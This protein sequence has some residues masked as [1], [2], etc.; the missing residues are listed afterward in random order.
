[1]IIFEKGGP[2]NTQACCSIAVEKAIELGCD[3]VSATS[4]G[5]SAL[6]MS[7][8][9]AEMGFKGRLVF[10]THAYGSREPGKNRMSDERRKELLDAGH[11]LVTA[12]HLLSGAERGLSARHKGVYPVEI[13]ADTLRMICAGA[14]VCVECAC[15]ALDNGAIE[16][17]KPIISVGGTGKGSDTAVV[18]TPAHGGNILATRVHEFLCKPY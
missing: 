3:I 7:R 10:V 1:M 2:V 8:I 16:Y 17:G 13:M 6:E 4:E 14:K 5:D 11:T 18:M 12:T 9:A 15:M